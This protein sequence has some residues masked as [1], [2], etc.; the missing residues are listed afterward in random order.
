ME[1]ESKKGGRLRA[2]WF[3]VMKWIAQSK[4]PFLAFEA[5]GGHSFLLDYSPPQL[6]IYSP[7][8][9]LIN[10]DRNREKRS[11]AERWSSG[12]PRTIVLCCSGG[13]MTCM[14][15][16]LLGTDNA[17]TARAS[18]PVRATSMIAGHYN[19]QFDFEFSRKFEEWLKVNVHC[20]L[21]YSLQWHSQGAGAFSFFQEFSVIIHSFC[22]WKGSY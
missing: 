22:A 6:K 15:P 18:V 2:N 20:L 12:V 4:S 11:A 16:V 14:H 10:L 9:T 21:I 3:S 1:A 8:H 5:C 13:R 7:L 17:T 19:A